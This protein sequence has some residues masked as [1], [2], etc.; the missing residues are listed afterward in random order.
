MEF[1]EKIRLVYLKFC[2]LEFRG[3][4]SDYLWMFIVCYRILG[5]RDCKGE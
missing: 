3:L 2:Y 4:F 1:W 5:V